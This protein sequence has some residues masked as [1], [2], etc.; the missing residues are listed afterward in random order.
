MRASFPIALFLILTSL[1]PR[2]TAQ[3]QSVATEKLQHALHLADL[4]NWADASPD[5]AEA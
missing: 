4:Y 3:A 5:F 2:M 1:L